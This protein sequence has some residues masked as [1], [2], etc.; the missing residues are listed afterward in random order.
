MYRISGEMSSNLTR[1]LNQFDKYFFL[2]RPGFK[3]MH[4]LHMHHGIALLSGRANRSAKWDG[5]RKGP[6]NLCK[7]T[8]LTLLHFC[9]SLQ[10]P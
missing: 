8:T 10:S 1:F 5:R 9:H 2:D 3:P 4:K 6:L 7:Y